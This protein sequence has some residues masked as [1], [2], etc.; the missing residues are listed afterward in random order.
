MPMTPVSKTLYILWRACPNNAWLRLH[1]PEVYFAKPP[2]EY[3]QSML[4]VGVDVE[5]AG[6]RLFEGATLVVG[7]SPAAK[8]CELLGQQTP[9]VFQAAFE[10]DQLSAFVDVLRY[11]RNTGEYAV[12]EIKAST[13]SNPEYL[14]DLAFQVLLLRRCG[15]NVG[16]AY[17]LQLDAN[18]RRKGR[19]PVDEL[20]ETVDLTDQIA[21]R[22]EEIEREIESARNYLLSETEPKGPCACIYKGRANHCATFGYSNPDIP[23]YGVHDLAHIGSSPKKLKE[24]VDAGIF[25]LADVPAGFAL[26]PAQ[27]TQI[28]VYRSGEPIIQKRAI[29]KEL[30]ELAFPL[31]FIDYETFAPAVPLF[32]DYSPY[33]PI[34][35][36]YSLHVIGAPGEE[37]VHRE[38]VHAEATDPSEAFARSLTEHVAPFGSILVW[39]KTFESSVND[40]MARRLPHFRDYFA[41]FSDR[42]Y[43]LKDIFAKQFFVHRDFQGS[44]SIKSVLPVLAPHLS[45]KNLA[46]QNGTAASN[47]WGELLSSALTGH[48]GSILRAQLAE[49][50]SL[51]SYGMVAIW[52]TLGK[53]AGG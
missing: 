7:E 53:V 18:F 15:L 5:L 31:H 41:E 10:Q 9:I 14:Y 20:F 24:L 44:T 13:K 46:I 19:I 42:M 51:D 26:S 48:E 43:D 27:K 49:Y 47:A 33:E 52:S 2:S 36:E 40:C 38:F 37:P 11:D 28:E 29:A 21:Q 39:N 35:L 3:D 12:F 22:A 25:S 6:R 23:T 8:T 50:C 45:Y 17:L 32:D 4:D 30:G 1:K 34:P 16:R